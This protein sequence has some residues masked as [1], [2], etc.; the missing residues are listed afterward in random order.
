[1][2]PLKKLV[3]GNHPL[4]EKLESYYFI[5]LTIKLKS[6]DFTIQSLVFRHGVYQ[7]HISTG[8]YTFLGNLKCKFGYQLL[9]RL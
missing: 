5:T 1:M 9:F 2:K 4:E 6:K 8:I 7:R 3:Y